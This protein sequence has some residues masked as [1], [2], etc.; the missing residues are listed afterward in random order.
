MSSTPSSAAVFSPI[1]I[2]APKPKVYVAEDDDDLRRLLVE[3]LCEAEFEVLAASSGRDM[4]KLFSAAARGEVPLPD[5]IVMD[6]RMPKCSGVDVLS[7]LRAAGWEQ[8]VVMITAFGDP[9]LHADATRRGAS[10][11]LDKPFDASDLVR[12]LDI[13][14]LFTTGADDAT[15]G[16]E[17]PPTIRC[18]TGMA[19]PAQN[20]TH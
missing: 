6:V 11:V 9:V 2:E 12:V 18:P 13:L 20:T 7:A 14:L 8:P 16:D 17:P 4:L 10:I 5:A 1:A 19:R 15:E 3:T